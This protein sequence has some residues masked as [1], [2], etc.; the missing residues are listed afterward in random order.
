MIIDVHAHAGPWFFSTEV[1]A[2]E[3]NLALMDRYGIDRQIVSASEAVTYDMVSGNKWM[4]ERLAEQPRLLGYLVI[5]PNELA[6][7]ETELAR[8]LAG[9]RFVGVKIHTT[10]P[11][12]ALMSTPV[13]DALGLAARANLPALIHT[14][15]DSVLGLVDVLEE[16]EELRVIAGHMGGPAWRTAVEAASR[17]DRLYLEPCCS[18][19]DRGKFRYAL[20]RVPVEQM[21][22]GTDSTLVDP[23]IALG[24]V[25]DAK[26]TE[27]EYEHVM[28]RNATKLFGIDEVAA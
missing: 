17:S 19:T 10:Y 1:G 2:V 5:N 24:V 18:I 22:F 14:W 26:M 13:R 6:E 3:L 7:A 21:M 11:E 20:D 16:H 8:H 25:A 27:R 28:W 15:D 12:Q 23:A 4:A 9:G